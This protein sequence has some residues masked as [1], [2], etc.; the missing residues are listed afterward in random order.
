MLR[1]IAA[2]PCTFSVE[3]RLYHTWPHSISSLLRWSYYTLGIIS[4]NLFGSNTVRLNIN[5]SSPI[6]A[7]LIVSYEMIYRISDSFSVIVVVVGVIVSLIVLI[8]VIR[9]LFLVA[10]FLSL[11]CT[12]SCLL[13]FNTLALDLLD[14]F[15]VHGG[16]VL[17]GHETDFHLNLFAFGLLL[18]FKLLDALAFSTVSSNFSIGGRLGPLARGVCLG[19]AGWNLELHEGLKTA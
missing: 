16:N 13:L 5:L 4:N 15:L 11:T 19:L 1:V 14:L 7:C 18:A 3:L 2:A 12:S 10:F 8:T 9:R 17:F 6:F